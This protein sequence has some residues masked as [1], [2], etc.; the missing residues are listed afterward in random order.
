MP[1]PNHPPATAELATLD[2][3]S[4]IVDRSDPAELDVHIIRDNYAT[5]HMDQTLERGPHHPPS[6]SRVH[7]LIMVSDPLS[8]R[9]ARTVCGGAARRAGVD[10]ALACPVVV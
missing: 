3:V 9:L 7:G 5:P 1:V 10:G 2:A 6:H 8:P 4:V